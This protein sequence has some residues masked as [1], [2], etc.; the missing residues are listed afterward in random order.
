MRK[1]MVVAVVLL[2]CL[3]MAAPVF[4]Q[5]Y[6]IAMVVKGAGNPFFEACRKGGEE[7]AA[8]LG[9]NFIFQAPE[10]PTAEG[11]IAIIDALIAQRVDAILISANDPDALVPV[12]RRAMDRGIKVVAFDS[13]V[14]PAGRHLFLNQAD[15]ELIGRIQVQ[16]LAEMIDFQGEIAILSAASTMANQNT[17]IEWMKEELKLPQYENMKLVSI[18]YGDDLR[19]KSYTEALGLFR[20][21]PN[22]RGIISPT[23][24]GV[25]ATARAIE[26]QGLSGKIALTGLGLPS[27]MA[28]YIRNGTCEAVALWN[29]IDLGYVSTYMAH[30]LLTGEIKGAAGETVKIGRMGEREIIQTADGGL[31]VVLG[32][33]FVFDKDNIDDWYLVY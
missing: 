6:T 15:M 11:Q 1:L 33:P 4:A 21:Y 32:A 19:E 18:V 12:T 8:E 5:K 29:P 13:A 20:A 7:A 24:V 14:A 22:L 27:E 10:T 16:L 25:A 26:D 23:T 28:E 3:M 9:I 30:A 17:W 2:A 31:E